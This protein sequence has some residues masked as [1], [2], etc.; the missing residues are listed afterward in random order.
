MTPD[1]GEVDMSRLM[2]SR[3]VFV[4]VAVTVGLYTVCVGSA[5]ASDVEG[6]MSPRIAELAK[7]LEK[8]R[9]VEVEAVIGSFIE[10]NRGEFPL[11]EDSLVTFVYLGKV[12]LSASVPSDINRWDVKAQV[13]RRLGEAD[14][15]CLTL[16][17]P[18]DARIDYKFYVDQLWMMDPLNDETVLGGFGPNSAFS[19]SGY[20]PPTE[21]EYVDTVAHGTIEE[22]EFASE[23]I[24]TTRKIRVYLP[25]G[26][27]P[28]KQKTVS[29]LDGGGTVEKDEGF[30]G[31]YPVIYVQDGGEYID[32][33][34]M[35]NILDNMIFEGRIPPIVAVFIDPVDRNYEY[36]LN[37][38]YEQ[39]LIEEVMPMIAG[40][41]DVST[42]PEKTAIMG[43]S[44]GGAI[45]L[46]V[47]MDR[48]DLF[49]NCGSQSGAF[50]VDE[51]RLMTMVE[52]SPARPV[53]V[54]LDCGTFGD[55]TAENRAMYDLFVE[56]GYRAR[57]QE[58]HEGHSWGNW[59]A[60]I[61]DMLAFFWGKEGEAK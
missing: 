32:L 16:Q 21:I 11:I 33:A 48:P 60:H 19:M 31:T 12:A 9:P 27:R 28:L 53:A 4:F 54:Y 51:G 17:L 47:A 57:Y 61:D 30:A 13:M 18:L 25:D 38:S 5:F 59:R 15:Y 26:Y 35:D 44:L 8:A 36:F 14:F 50:E 43:A 20:V 58:F 24:P 2:M 3:G 34:S 23:I 49:G 37:A 1:K 10:E 42:E 52:Q 56:K 22:H 7:R 55:L 39:M 41:Y 6:Q 46:M 40:K 29:A 45:S